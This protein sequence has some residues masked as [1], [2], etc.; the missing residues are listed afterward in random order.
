MDVVSGLCGDISGSP[1]LREAKRM[2]R[3][4]SADQF[5]ANPVPARTV[6]VRRPVA[7]TDPRRF[8]L[9]A[10]YS[11]VDGTQSSRGPKTL[12]ASGPNW[13]RV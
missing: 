10:L 3:A 2:P 1:E 9:S 5:A 12:K 6:R 7:Q 11:N 4:V 8:S 13:F